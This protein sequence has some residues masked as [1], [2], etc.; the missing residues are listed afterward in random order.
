MLH[1]TQQAH[2]QP[3]KFRSW[4]TGACFAIFVAAI[5]L[6]IYHAFTPATA[7]A[8]RLCENSDSSVANISPCTGPTGTT[9]NINLQR[10]LKSP[11]AALI[12]KRA[13]AGGVPAQVRVGVSG[14]SAAAP[15]ELCTGGSGR[16]E[17]W[18]VDAAGASQGFIGAFWP[19][20]SAASSG[21]SGA[22]GTGPTP[23]GGSGA[24]QRLCEN[25]DAAVASISPCTGPTGTKITVTL[26]R[27]LASP[28]KTLLFKRVLA[29]GVPAQV[30]ADISSGLTATTTAQICA[31]GGGKWEVWLVD[32]A[33]ASQGLIGVFWPACGSMDRCLLGSWLATSVTPLNKSASGATGGAGYRVT[34]TADGGESIDYS[35]TAPLVFPDSTPANPDTFTYRGNAS[36]HISTA[37]GVAKIETLDQQAAVVHLASAGRKFVQKIPGLGPGGL[38]STANNNAY[39]CAGDTLEYRASDA[40]DKHPTFY[41][42]LKRQKH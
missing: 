37:N 16:W 25:S 18:L 22:G 19:D 38:G 24:S 7:T 9:I 23:G 31:E 4:K 17:V 5:T 14:L 29:S 28:P 11:P 2:A 15:A 32:A 13:V 36:A 20:C 30:R 12:F 35:T 39:T 6:G 42:K 41:V 40:V 8:Q 1:S 10:T 3:P 34:F 27:K 21:S 33:G 26:R